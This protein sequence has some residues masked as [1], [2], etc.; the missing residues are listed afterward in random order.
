MDGFVVRWASARLILR[1]PVSVGFCRGMGVCLLVMLALAVVAW[2]QTAQELEDIFWQE[3]VCER[4]RE[5]EAYLKEYPSGTYVAKARACLAAIARRVEAEEALALDRQ[6]II[7]VQRGLA[8]LNYPVGVP[9]GQLRQVTRTALLQWQ[10]AR[11][12]GATGYLTSAQVDR[13]TAAGRAEAVRQLEEAERRQAAR[14]ARQQAQAQA[15]D[16]EAALDLDRQA[17]IRV[18]QGLMS[19]DYPVEVADGLFGPTTRLALQNWQ[20]AKGF[21][22]TGY[23]T[24]EQATALIEAGGQRQ[25][26]EEVEQRAAAEAERRR[27]E[28]AERQQA[29]ETARQREANELVNTMVWSSCES[30]QGHSGWGCRRGERAAAMTGLSIRFTSASRFIWGNTK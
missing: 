29:Q 6:T 17:R 20:R 15:Q 10:E 4:T 7:W 9:D 1:S 25:A 8:A 2:G 5:V 14:A 21:T 13:L 19:L 22:A 24:S 27:A 18:Q 12:L 26:A 11:G 3:V 30:R 28:E 16:T 23:L